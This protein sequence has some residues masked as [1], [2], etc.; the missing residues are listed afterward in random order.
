MIVVV[1]SEVAVG[2][3]GL[4]VGIIFV[5]SIGVVIA[6]FVELEAVILV[7][8]L[9]LLINLLV[10]ING[11]LVMIIIVI[12]NRIFS[13]LVWVIIVKLMVLF[14]VKVKNGISVCIVLLKNFCNL[15]L[16]FFRVKFI[17]NGNIALMKICGLNEVILVVFR[18]IIVM[19]GL[20]FNDIN[21]NVLVFFFVLYCC[22]ME[23]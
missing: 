8:L 13:K 11:I 9:L 19:S 14:S 10:I 3:I 23:V 17:R 4:N 18:I 6:V 1:I 16:R 2:V 5:I 7:V 22:M 20:D 12:F 15:G 21:I